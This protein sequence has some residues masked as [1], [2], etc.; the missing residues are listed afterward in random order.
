MEISDLGNSQT[1]EGKISFLEIT[2][3]MRNQLLRDSDVMS[4]SRGLEL[5]VPLVDKTLLETVTSIPSNI[6][7]A[8]GKGILIQEIPELPDW[9]IN[10]KKQGFSF[11][12]DKWISGELYDCFSNVKIP[13]NISLKHWY[14]RWSLLTLQNWCQQINK[15]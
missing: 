4:M 12:F 8:A 15:Y 1:L 11:P 2:S 7:L 9:V 3:Y 6:R 13:K 5:R 10:R 14:C